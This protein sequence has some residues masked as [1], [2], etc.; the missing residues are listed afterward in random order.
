MHHLLPLRRTAAD[1]IRHI[2]EAMW[3]TRR[4]RLR[5]V[6]RIRTEPRSTPFSGIGLP[7]RSRR[8]AA[9]ASAGAGAA[10]TPPD[11][12]T[13][14]RG[15]GGKDGEIALRPGAVAPSAPRAAWIRLC[16]G[17]EPVAE[18]VRPPASRAPGGDVAAVPQRDRGDHGAT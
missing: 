6:V 10:R 17:F 18:H 14:A 15:G 3:L 8:T 9:T 1:R 4:E 11:S 13:C 12:L 2:P 5:R 16:Q 7:D